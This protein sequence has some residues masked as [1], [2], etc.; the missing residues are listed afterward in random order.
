MSLPPSLTHHHTHPP[1]RVALPLT[2]LPCP[3]PAPGGIGVSFSLLHDRP[4]PNISAIVQG[5]PADADGTLRAG[6]ALIKVL[7]IRCSRVQPKNPSP[8]RFTLTNCNRFSPRSMEF[9]WRIGLYRASKRQSWAHQAPYCTSRCPPIRFELPLHPYSETKPVIS[10]ADL[11]RW[12]LDGS[13]PCCNVVREAFAHH[14]TASPPI[15]RPN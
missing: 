15:P 13:E 7:N 12:A 1:A 6:D 11:H 2:P 3:F 8:K 14:F 4:V 10:E 9:R 5:G